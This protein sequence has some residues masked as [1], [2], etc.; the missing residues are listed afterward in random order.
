MSIKKS[1]Q[2]NM[3]IVASIPLFIFAVI[4]LVTAF[5]NYMSVSKVA[6]I[7]T[8]RNNEKGIEAQL[9]T[10]IA[11]L[12]ALANNNDILTLLLK[13]YNDPELDLTAMT[14]ARTDIHDLL[15]QTSASFG[16]NVIYSVYDIDGTLVFS[17]VD[18]LV[19]SSSDYI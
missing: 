4:M 18:S 15:F 2:S 1:L 12:E 14:Q 8:A 11:E 5:N 16:Q 13:K 17:Y 7:S 3:V 19:G 6:A 10:Q 9:S